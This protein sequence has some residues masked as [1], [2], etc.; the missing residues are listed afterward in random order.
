MQSLKIALLQCDHV[1][2]H[3]QPLGGDYPEMFKTFLPRGEFTVYDVCHDIF[4]DSVHAADIYMVTGSKFSVYDAHPWIE[5][6]KAFI[7]DI[8]IADKYFI[9]VCFGHQLLAEALDGRVEKGE[10]GWCVG[11]HTFTLVEKEKWMNPYQSPFNILMSCQDQVTLLPKNSRVLARSSDCAVGMFQ[12]GAKMLGIQ[13]HPEF[14]REYSRALMEARSELI[15]PSKT[16]KGIAS[17]ALPLDIAVLEAW[18]INFI[19]HERQ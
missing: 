11:V 18:F 15:G 16:Q 4:P 8:S 17:L 6:L 10:A 2:E 19:D 7:R 13:G 14:P 12:V 5:K 9:G 1:A 3:L